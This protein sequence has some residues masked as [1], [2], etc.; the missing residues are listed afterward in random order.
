MIIGGLVYQSTKAHVNYIPLSF[1]L[2]L[3]GDYGN[4]PRAFVLIFVFTDFLV[5]AKAD[6]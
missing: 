5:E 3:T 1:V 4:K 2:S 6:F